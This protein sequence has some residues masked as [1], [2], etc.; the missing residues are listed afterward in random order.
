MKESVYIFLLVFVCVTS[1]LAEKPNISIVYPENNASVAAV[2]S[3]FIFGSVTPGSA[4]K[5]NGFEVPVHRDGGFL[6]FLPIQPGSYFYE[7]IAIKGK[8]TARVI[9]TINV[10]LPKTSFD[11]NRL[12]IRIDE[13][14]GERYALSSGEIF[15]FSFQGTPGCRAWASI[16]GYADSIP[17]A[18]NFPREQPFWGRAVFGE[19]AIPDSLK[20]KGIYSG[21]IRIDD[22]VIEDSVRIRYNLRVPDLDYI[23]S[24]MKYRPSHDIDFDILNLLKLKDSTIGGNSAFHLRINPS[25][26]PVTVQ[27]TDSVQR[28]RVEPGKGYLSIFQPR[29]VK[30]IALGENRGWYRLKLS[31]TQYGWVAKESVMQ[32]PKGILP[33]RSF[34][35][36]VRMFSER[37]R[38]VIEI[39]L[40]EVHPYRVEETDENS[41][42]L[43][44][45][46]ADSDTDWL[47]YD[48][49]DP[50]L[51][52]IEWSQPEPQL[53]KLTLTL[54]RPIWGYD[55]LYDGTVMKF[56]VN[57]PPDKVGSLKGKVIVIDPGHSPDRGAV[58][59][60]GLTEKDANL[61]IALR[62]EDNLMRK[63]AK[64]VMTRSDGI[65]IPLYD[66]PKVAAAVD[67]DLFVSVHNN[68][69]PDGINPFVNN[70]SSV[71]YYHRHSFEL[72]KD[73]YDR[74]VA[75]TALPRYGLYH[76]NLAVTRSTQ[77]P[78]VLVECA[79][80]MLPEQEAALKT[81]DFQ[82]DIAEAI[83]KGIEEFLKDYE[84][85]TKE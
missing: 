2:D 16:P 67:A 30:A 85:R 49:N 31:E 15:R 58:G 28:M 4:L 74:L 10:P 38:A 66:R 83:S 8:D 64:V 54:R 17:M 9:R 60:T 21:F 29:G 78:A 47:R 68:A 19:G 45:Y 44:I 40:S 48:S 32:L 62:L 13:N 35:K 70:G 12:K 33:A 6:A 22:R 18:E 43:Y 77:Y 63:G 84:R 52:F 65:G 37:D 80:M 56:I 34:V 23:I 20:I 69:L 53:Y 26:F 24:Y 71:Y 73:V 39:P 57:R 79:F 61:N 41:I 75:A 82:N 14:A 59:P 42:S 7:V 51:E 81:K 76:G 46:G 27:F 1:A 36:S 55:V 5:I 25:N 11:Y 50:D 72:A 3:N